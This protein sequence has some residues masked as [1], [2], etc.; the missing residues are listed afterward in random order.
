MEFS[1]ILKEERI[2]ANL[3]QSELAKQTG[4]SVQTISGYETGTREPKL[5]TLIL[6]SDTFGITVDQLL[7]KTTCEASEFNNY[8]EQH[9]VQM[10]RA[11][12]DADKEKVIAIVKTFHDIGKVTKENDFHPE[13]SPAS[14]G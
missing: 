10:F 5:E 3:K 1:R 6:L 8:R 4:L 11:L 9:L 12:S 2:K 7:G 13:K 14:A